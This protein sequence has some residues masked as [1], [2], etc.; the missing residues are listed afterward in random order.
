MNTQTIKIAVILI[1]VAVLSYSCSKNKIPPY[2]D[3]MLKVEVRVND[4]LERMTIEEKV[5]QMLKL[6][7]P[8]LKEDKHGNI[9]AESLDSLFQ[10]QSI[11]C[12]DPPRTD[13]NDIAKYS[14]AAD[15]YLRENTRLG[16]PAIQVELGGIHGQLALG[17]TNFP[18]T[19]GQG[20]TWNPELIKKMAEVMA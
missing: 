10:G 8:D 9:T 2:K 7:L 12:L 1:L 15:H 18:Q 5:N 20:C 3:S 16:I 13:I 17:A 6:V 14:E 11:G 19:I 4:L